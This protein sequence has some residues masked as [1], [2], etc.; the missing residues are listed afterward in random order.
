MVVSIKRRDFDYYIQYSCEEDN[1]ELLV[2]NVHEWDVEELKDC[3]HFYTLILGRDE[4]IPC[5]EDKIEVVRTDPYRK[6]VIC[7]K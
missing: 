1:R 4:E 2:Y 3:E 5:E 7:R 6:Y